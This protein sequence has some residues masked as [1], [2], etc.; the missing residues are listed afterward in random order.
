MTLVSAYR[1]SKELYL[2]LT[3]RELRSKYKRSFLGWAWSLV[4]PLANMAVYTVVFAYF[5]KAKPPPGINGLDVYALSLMCALLPWNFFSASV[6][7]SI[8]TL[9]GNG[10]LIKKTYFP[11]QLLPAATV[12]AAL[13]THLIEMGLLIVVLVGFGDWQAATFLPFVLV[14]MAVNVMFS[15]GL[16]LLL[17]ALNVY[18]RDIEHFMGIVLLVWLYMTPIIYPITSVPARFRTPLKANPMT[19]MSTAFR[20]VLYYGRLPSWSAFVYFLGWAVALLALGWWVFNKLQDGLAEE[21]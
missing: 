19:E 15:L 3:L 12:G 20:S 10:P 21:L 7:G 17:S 11:R 1:S 14:L 16:G 8:G 6:M 13:V 2:N 18:F 9:V 5:L 4:N